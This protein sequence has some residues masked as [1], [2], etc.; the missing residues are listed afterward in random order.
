MKLQQFYVC[1]LYFVTHLLKVWL[2][3][4]LEYVRC[5]KIAISYT[6]LIHDSHDLHSVKKVP[7]INHSK[8]P[9]KKIIKTLF[10]AKLAPL[11]SILTW[12]SSAICHLVCSQCSILSVYFKCVS[13]FFQR[14]RISN[15]EFALNFAL[16]M[17]FRLS[18]IKIAT[19]LFVSQEL[20]RTILNDCLGIKRVAAWLAPKD[21][22]IRL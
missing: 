18:L 12:S 10:D 19:E 6:H 14:I 13:L 2:E 15:K 3:M 9:L 20:I 5:I 1:I 11:S 21:H 4:P 8:S 17:E 16:Q 7:W 22:L